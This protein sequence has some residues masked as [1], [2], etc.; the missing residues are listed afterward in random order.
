MYF[1]ASLSTCRVFCYTFFFFS[2]RR[3]HTI[4]ALVTGVQTF[5]L[6]ISDALDVARQSRRLAGAGSCYFRFTRTQR[7]C[8]LISWIR[9]PSARPPQTTPSIVSS[10]LP[11]P[12]PANHAGSQTSLWP[13]GTARIAGTFLSP[14]CSRSEEHKSELQSL[15]R[16]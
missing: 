5:A 14:F 11:D 1:F 3:R 9:D 8:S 13:G 10:Q 16:N 2:S 6:P 7:C 4:C 12:T 15:M